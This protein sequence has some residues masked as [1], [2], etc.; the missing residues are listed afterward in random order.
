MFAARLLALRRPHWQVYVHEGRPPAETFGFAVGLTGGLLEALRNSDSAMSQAV[1]EAAHPFSRSGFR[2]PQGNATLTRF[3]TGA[4][5]RT[6]LLRLLLNGA[7][8]AGVRACVGRARDVTDLLDEAD[9]VIAADG[10]ASPTRYRYREEFGAEVTEGRNQF[11]WCGAVARLDGGVFMPVHTEDGLFVAHAYPYG[12]TRS[13]FVVEASRETLDRAGLGDRTRTTDS[14]SDHEA[15][16]HLSEAFEPLLGGGSLTGNQSRWSP[17]HTVRCARWQHDKVVLLGDAAATT[18]PSLGSGTKIAM[19]SAIALV[20]ALTA[21]QDESLTEALGR[22]ESARRPKVERLQERAGRSQLWWESFEARQH[23]GP[24]RTALSYLTRAGAVSLDDLTVS[25]PGLV[26]RALTEFAGTEPG[27]AAATGPGLTRWVLG[28]PVHTPG[29]R[30]ASRLRD[31]AAADT[32]TL[33][34][35]SGDAWGPGADSLLDRARASV[36]RG[37][38]VIR[39]TGADSRGSLLDRLAFGE[40]LR[41][42]L[43]VLVEVT[44]GARHLRDAVDGVVTGRTDLVH[45]PDAS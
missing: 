14:T 33:E 30:Y 13:T 39:L 38:D 27:H 5:S 16:K 44:S 19:E 29:N 24:A 8:A 28:Q 42:E 21:A 11:L 41:V 12:D 35:R 32:A 22:F 6:R 10:A 25:D 36:D 3:H 4:I 2:L 7:L 45:V 17:F 37:A 20:D 23:L 15:L 31:N 18:H 43:P 1:T 40:R 34:V 26:S 9:L